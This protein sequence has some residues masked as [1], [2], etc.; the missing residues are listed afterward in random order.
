MNHQYLGQFVF[1][2]LISVG[3]FLSLVA[4]LL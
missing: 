1:S 3:I 2:V 4:I